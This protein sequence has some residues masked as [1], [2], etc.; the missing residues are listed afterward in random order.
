[1]VDNLKKQIMT[2]LKGLNEKERELLS[3][4]LIIEK[5]KLYQDR[6]RVKD[7]LLKAVREVYK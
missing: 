4:V 1:M 3:R 6:P 5:D 2:I 7:D